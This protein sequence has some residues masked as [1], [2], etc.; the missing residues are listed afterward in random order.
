MAEENPRRQRLFDYR[1]GLS[2]ETIRLFAD[3]LAGGNDLRVQVTGDSMK[4]FFQSGDIATIR[5]VPP[6]SLRAGDVILCLRDDRELILHRLLKV[7]GKRLK[8]GGAVY[9]TKGD[10]LDFPDQPFRADQ[11]LGKTVYLERI[12][13]QG[14]VPVDMLSR[15][16]M[17]R[18]RLRAWY[19]RFR[20]GTLTARRIGCV[21]LPGG[22]RTG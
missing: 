17:I 7:Q 18:N 12:G 19:H 6:A 14:I 5:A 8:S 10:A 22:R 1:P 9:H 13:A 16:V 2:A 4:P 21:L 15:K 11:C 20:S 3:I